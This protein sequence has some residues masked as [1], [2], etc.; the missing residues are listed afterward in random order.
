MIAKHIAMRSAKRSSF[1][2][3]A[4]YI[5]SAHG[6]NERVG[7]VSVT[8]FKHDEIAGA[9][10][11][12]GALQS[13]NTRA[14][15]DKTYHL[16]ISF[17]P[18]ESPDAATLRAAEKALCDGL[19]F[20]DHQRISA[21]HYDTDNVHIHIAINKIHP[22][23]RNLIEPYLAY[24]RMG[25]VCAQ[26][27][28]D[29]GLFITNHQG[30]KNGG[31][32]RADDMAQASG[33]E[34][35]RDW[36]RRTCIDELRGAA[37]WEAFHAVAAANGLDVQQRGAGLVI[38]GGDG[39][40][41]KPSTVARELGKASLE[42]RLGAFQPPAGGLEA[43]PPMRGYEKRPI[44]TRIDTS[45]LY[46]RYKQ[47]DSAAR[48]VRSEALNEARARRD[49][50]IAGA[51]RR[52][53]LERAAIKLTWQGKRVTYAVSSHQLKRSIDNARARFQRDRDAIGRA[54]KPQTWA[55]WLQTQAQQGDPA[56]LAA[57]RAR[58]AVANNAQGLTI[59]P[60]TATV[61]AA[62]IGGAKI[63]GV[64][65]AGTIIFHSAHAAIRDD[66]SRLSV[67]RGADIAGI[68]EA[69]RVARARY[70]NLLQIEGSAQFCA[71]VAAVAA[72]S[73]PEV[74]FRDP[75][76]DRQR[77]EFERRWQELGHDRARHSSG[78]G[79]DSRPRAAGDRAGDGAPGRRAPAPD[80]GVTGRAGLWPA[81]RRIGIAAAD[82]AGK[83]YVGRVTSGPP[84]GYEN[85]LRTVSQLDVVRIG[86]RPEMLLPRDAQRQLE[87][88][89]AEPTTGVRREV[90]RVA[91]PDSAAESYI[92]ERNS[93]RTS[94]ADIKQHM[95]YTGVSETLTF[96]GVRS[97]EGQSLALFE[98]GDTILVKPIDDAEAAALPRQRGQQVKI[99]DGRVAARQGRRRGR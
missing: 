81:V 69:L 35:L 15:G 19:G 9:V 83:P 4:S 6:K 65:K 51:K 64:T 3:L 1:A 32:N 47:E 78:V 17:A 94:M 85:R 55:D 58:V 72:A 28:R 10:A 73:M 43:P 77:A 52:A 96:V 89:R 5:T 12:A 26:F 67:S 54:A 23:R 39:A 63:D 11:E 33:I 75:G 88:P 20:A 95:R 7:E 16:V 40:A 44:A 71:R 21:V 29:H 50:E 37:T 46:G 49:V 92:T 41:I 57:L 84:P 14:R 79:G 59:D 30:Q 2:G 99:E 34:P 31:E 87:H 48:V 36:I 61:G 98:R 70:G 38:V 86:V 18:G 66:G 27:E 13:W 56:A 25:E 62:P 74:R 93:K 22:S 90:F 24:R 80:A 68:V 82:I 76:L 45:A 8:N 53:N 97:I 60:G 91:S 42:K